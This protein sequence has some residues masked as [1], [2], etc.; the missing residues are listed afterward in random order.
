M[1]WVEL[2]AGTLE[3]A[4]TGGGGPVLVLLHGVPMTPETQWHAVLPHLAGH[5]VVLPTLPMGGHRRPML[6]GADLT[7][8]GMAALVGE[9][10]VAFDLNDVVLVLNDW[11]GG[12]FLLTERMPGSERVAGLALVACE[13][14]DNFPPGP[15]KA[16]ETVARMPG[17]MWLLLQAMRLKPLRQA[18][19]GY[20]GM[21]RRGIPDNVLRGWFTP[22]LRDAGVRR[23]FA[24]FAQGAPSSEVL[25]AAAER[26]AD[27]AGPALVVWARQ[28]TMMPLEHGRR[29]AELIPHARLVE[30]DD[31]ATLVP[32]DQPRLLAHLL[33]GLAREVC[34]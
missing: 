30:V 9:L 33:T 15:A 32:M 31:S 24:A 13:A 26:L 14:F 2:S 10:L 34:G 16:M 18:R 17:G 28:D 27:F 12:Q 5:R 4:D 29:L 7:Q 22:A 20:G 23:D 25:L 21:S 6:P 8:F 1:P 3:Y 19:F 11:G